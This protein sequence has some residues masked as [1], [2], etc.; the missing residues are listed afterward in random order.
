MTV[1]PAE[2]RRELARLLQ[3]RPVFVGIGNTLRSDDGLG[4]VLVGR[5]A[6]AAPSV[7]CIDAGTSPENQVGSILRCSPGAVIAADAVHLGREPGALALLQR[8]EIV[9][10]TGLGTH[11]SSPGLFLGYLGELTGAEIVMLA[12]QP[13]GTGFGEGLSDPVSCALDEVVSLVVRSISTHTTT[14]EVPDDSSRRPDPHSG[15]GGRESRSSTSPPQSRH[16]E[17]G[18]TDLIRSSGRPKP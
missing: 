11:D 15:H 9:Q 1:L 4:P 8:D 18:G 12:V 17:S 14:H 13:A 10:Y 2:I 7:P 6:C 3:N 5:L 16:R